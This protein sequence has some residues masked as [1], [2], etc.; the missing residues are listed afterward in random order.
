MAG[1][2]RRG[3]ELGLRRHNIAEVLSV[4][5]G[6]DEVGPLSSSRLIGPSWNAKATL[7]KGLEKRAHERSVALFL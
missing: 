7:N 1:S 2:S 4:V 3:G 6:T 5:A